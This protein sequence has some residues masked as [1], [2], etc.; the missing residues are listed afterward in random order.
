[1]STYPGAIDQYSRKA[2]NVDTILA[3]DVNELQSGIENI[4]KELGTE[5]SGSFLTVKARLDFIDTQL[6]DMTVIDT[7][8]VLSSGNVGDNS[9]L[10]EHVKDVSIHG[11][12]DVFAGN[13]Q[14]ILEST[15]DQILRGTLT[16][17]YP[18][19]TASITLTTTFPIEAGDM[20]FCYPTFNPV[21][22]G[23][24]WFI[25]TTGCGNLSDGLLRLNGQASAP[26]FADSS[27]ITI[28]KP[29]ASFAAD[30]SGEIELEPGTFVFSYPA[31]NPAS[32]G[33]N[34]F[35]S[36]AQASSVSEIRLND[37]TT[38][39]VFTAG[40]RISIF[41]ATATAE[42]SDKNL[43][44]AAGDIVFCSPSANPAGS[45]YN[46]HLVTTGTTA[47]VAGADLRLD[48][49]ASAPVFAGSRFSK[50]T[51]TGSALVNDTE[52]PMVN[53]ELAFC[54]PVSNPSASDY[55]WHIV[56]TG[57]LGVSSSSLRLD[58]SSLAP[59]FSSGS[60]F[61]VFKSEKYQGIARGGEVVELIYIPQWVM[62]NSVGTGTDPSSSGTYPGVYGNVSVKLPMGDNLIDRDFN[63]A[64]LELASGDPVQSSAFRPRIQP[65]SG[66]ADA[67]YPEAGMRLQ[68]SDSGS[69][70]RGV[71][72]AGII[73][74][75][76][77]GTLCE[78]YPTIKAYTGKLNAAK[79]WNCY[80][81]ML[82]RILDN[83]ENSAI[84]VGDYA[85]MIFSTQGSTDS[86]FITSA[87]TDS[88]SIDLFKL[89]Q[90]SI[91]T[92]TGED[93]DLIVDGTYAANST[94]GIAYPGGQLSA[95]SGFVTA[96]YGTGSFSAGTDVFYRISAVDSYGKETQA[97]T[98]FVHHTTTSG[99]GIKIT[100]PAITGATA[101]NVYGRFFG[102]SLFLKQVS[103]SEY[104]DN[105]SDNP[106]PVKSF[107]TTN[108]TNA[109]FLIDSIKNYTN[110]TVQ[111]G[112]AI[113]CTNWNYDAQS[114]GKI[115]FYCKGT[116]LVTNL[117]SIT[118]TGRGYKGGAPYYQGESY[119]RPGTAS[120]SRNAG[121][122]G[123]GNPYYAG[124]GGYGTAGEN[125]DSQGGET[126]GSRT[127]DVLYRGSGG[128]GAYV[129]PIYIKGGNGGGIIFISANSIVI[130]GNGI[131][132]ANGM[133]GSEVT[134][135]AGGSGGSIYL[136]ANNIEAG[137]GSNVK[138]VGGNRGGNGRIRFDYIDNGVS[139]STPAAYKVQL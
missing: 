38:A 125:G 26:V 89:P 56:N 13:Y 17:G 14:K 11:D 9:T 53:G 102:E 71:S 54:K 15:I 107:P 105:G 5:P 115:V 19:N 37:S 97:T 66:A 82:V 62:L 99:T 80:F 137:T 22:T 18:L 90:D 40:S 129:S 21:S 32:T 114:Y 124:G 87:I 60:R 46:W 133:D 84:N 16:S 28:V 93:G 131:I 36:T 69:V 126:Y 119:T 86:P 48:D 135:G 128:G 104:I 76:L 7:N 79:N 81:P 136:R 30:F 110:V 77:Y 108:E 112:G 103:T 20:V 57:S 34:W 123:A 61:S 58:N 101:Y 1:M 121:G 100:W 88:S 65:Y 85:V 35:M 42:V 23:Y 67:Y 55:G 24:G 83:A 117:S 113:S 98:R 78:G 52:L 44:I 29:F 120:T 64:A 138:A 6:G 109:S 43:H 96:D 10:E 116:V 41:E 139:E 111:N 25:A 4:E 72:G 45:G 127:L 106:N 70:E 2:D 91:Y 94:T 27:R 59:T 134:Y 33:Y 39:P 49:S 130:Q 47:G 95:P 74:R 92:G 3:N 73:N 118:A 8:V 31:S 75:E 12:P 132:E 63:S 51:V 68:L 50:F 122:G